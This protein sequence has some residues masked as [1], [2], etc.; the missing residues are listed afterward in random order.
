GKDCLQ[1]GARGKRFSP[2]FVSV[3]LYDK[4][5]IID[6]NY[7]IYDLKF[8]NNKFDI[9]VCNAILEHLEY[10]NKAILELQRV[11]KSGGLIWIEVPFNQPYHPSPSDYFRVT[12]VGLRVWMK[13]F[14]EIESGFF[15]ISRSE[16]YT[17]I[18]FYGRKRTV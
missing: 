8:D 15:K 12:P 6:F 17:R 10:P 9:V 3:D 4:S 1:I 2:A 14:E 7:D 16:I 5:P 18:F 11:L 13:D